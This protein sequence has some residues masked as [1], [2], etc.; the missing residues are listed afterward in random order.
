MKFLILD[1]KPNILE[2]K[3]LLNL[4]QFGYYAFKHYWELVKQARH[5]Q[6][7]KLVS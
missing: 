4:K 3:T 7:I 5:F 6:Y 2:I 1:F